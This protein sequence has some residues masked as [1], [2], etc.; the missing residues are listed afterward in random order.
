MSCQACGLAIG[1]VHS[2]WSGES[3]HIVW[4]GG[5]A[6]VAAVGGVLLVV[7]VLVMV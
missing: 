1:E 4:G 7:M 6:V 3:M 5:E 2:Q